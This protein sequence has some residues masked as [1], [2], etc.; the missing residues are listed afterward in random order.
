M[1]ERFARGGVAGRR[2]SS[3][4]AG[5]G[6]ALVDEH[7]RLHGGRVWVED[8][9]DGEPG[10]RFVLELPGRGGR[11]CEPAP[12]PSLARCV[13]G[14]RCSRACGIDTDDGAARH[15][16]AGHR[17]LDVAGRPDRRHRRPGR[18]VIYL[19]AP[20][21]AGQLRRC[22]PSP[23]TSTD[24]VRPTCCTALLAG[25]NARSERRS[26]AHGDPAG[27]ELRSA[28]AAERR[29]RC[30]IDVSDELA[31]RCPATR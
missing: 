16:R 17:Q 12:A 24:D 28:P 26:A 19:L 11:A 15:R 18:R 29:H 6:L 9:P 7:I 13:G 21:D 5:L 20:D 2:S 22:M 23:A 27:Y 25:P 1:F 10:A 8:R 14:A 4:G 31:R 30:T 3:D